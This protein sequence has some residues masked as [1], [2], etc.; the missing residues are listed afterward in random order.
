[1]YSFLVGY[2]LR[3]PNA[4][5]MWEAQFGDFANYAQGIIDTYIAT[6][7][8]RWQL[9]SNLV[10]LLPHGFEG[11]VRLCGGF[12]IPFRL[13]AWHALCRVPTTATHTW[14]DSC[15]SAPAIQNTSR[16]CRPLILPASTE[17]LIKL[18]RTTRVCNVWIT[19]SVVV[20]LECIN[21]HGSHG[22][23]CR[24]VQGVHYCSQHIRQRS[25]YSNSLLRLRAC[26]L[27]SVL[28]SR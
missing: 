12:A 16:G 6:G 27:S 9:R 14:S 10:M 26:S 3:H 24:V 25:W 1:M 23:R 20:S 5:V 17:G 19:I 4:L 7:E 15:R 18:M 21:A 28:G 8:D 22:G 11:Q 2:S 13:K